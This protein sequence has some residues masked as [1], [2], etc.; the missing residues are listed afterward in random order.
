MSA[1][2]SKAERDRRERLLKL[3]SQSIRADHK[4]QHQKEQQMLKYLETRPNYFDWIDRGGSREQYQRRY[5][6]M[7]VTR[8]EYHTMRPWH[9]W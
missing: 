2:E 4:E 6:E 5:P 1:R 8:E 7:F 3:I 9:A